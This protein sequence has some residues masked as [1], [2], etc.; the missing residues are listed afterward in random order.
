MDVSSWLWEILNELAIKYGYLGAFVLAIVSNMILFMP[1]PYLA[2]FFLLAELKTIDPIALG[3]LGG[4]GAGIGKLLSYAVGLG[5]R[6]II[7]EER[8]QN[9]DALK[10]MAGKYGALMAFIASMTPLPD[11]IFLIPL[12]MIKYDLMKY[13][14]AVSAGKTILTLFI[15]CSG[16]LFSI[17]MEWFMGEGSM[18]SIGIS[19][20]AFT[21]LTIFI[22][23]IDWTRIAAI[24]EREGARK[25]LEEV[26]DEALRLL[27]AFRLR[28]YEK[29]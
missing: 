5:T 16:R 11:D 13:F 20:I 26:F 21:L 8:V 2:A 3:L 7:R 27:R 15:T 29:K 28:G 22:L 12:G 17:I 25:A 10:R 19:I 1:V 9:L 6:K 14:V 4:V 23:K 18:L 24:L